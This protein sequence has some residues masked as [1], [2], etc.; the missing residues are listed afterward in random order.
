MARRRESVLLNVLAAAV[1]LSVVTQAD[2]L[3][4]L[5]PG[6]P[7][8]IFR[9]WLLNA[10]V[11]L[12]F[13]WLL[14]LARAGRHRL[15]ASLLLLSFGALG[16]V[17]LIAAGADDPFWPVLGSVTVVLAAMLLGGRA[18]AV[19]LVV[20]GL[21]LLPIAGLQ[22]AGTLQPPAA[23]PP[24]HPIGIGNAAG[25]IALLG[26]LAAICWLY[27]RDAFTSIDE[28]LTHNA[29]SSPLRR[30]RTKS[31]SMRE[32][33]VVQLV[34]AGLSNDA[35]ARR[36]FVSPRTVQ[37]H[38][39]SAMRKTESSNRTALGVLAIREGL[40]PLHE[41]GGALPTTFP[42]GRTKSSPGDV[43]EGRG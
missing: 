40:V 15:S 23:N 10:A 11:A 26:F 2:Q 36:L 30:L 9:W 19:S 1:V 14:R 17:Q 20:G 35:I 32:I 24:G 27:T 31:L 6:G 18:M 25:V 37:S 4:T 41:D 5:A 21:V 8:S 3:I 22:H 39:A 29:S 43:S 38:V 28:A 42:P 12:A 7:S 34:A 13:Y 16:V 33:E